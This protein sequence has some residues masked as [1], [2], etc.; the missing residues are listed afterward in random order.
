MNFRLLVAGLAVASVAGAC[1]GGDGDDRTT[2]DG[3]TEATNREAFIR[4]ADIICSTGTAAKADAMSSL[5]A[6]GS[7]GPEPAEVQKALG[8]VLD[9]TATELDKIRALD[10]PESDD[11]AVE[12]L[13]DETEATLDSVRERIATPEGAME[14][15]GSTEDP[16][17]ATNQ[18]L[19]DYGF[20]DCAGQPDREVT[21][22]FGG[23]ELTSD[24]RGGAT[25]VDVRA[26]EYAFAGVPATLPPKAAVFEFGNDGAEFHEMGLIRLKDGVDPAAALAKL[27]AD[28]DDRSGLERFV[29]AAMARPGERAAL[30]AKLTPGAYA[31][32]CLLETPDGSTHIAE[33]M[34]G[35][36]TVSVGI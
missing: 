8:Q 27:A 9:L 23:D 20:A 19:A 7:E 30:T 29:G 4:A 13:L 10:R 15:L 28:P 21:Q 16:F 31:F 17:A 11:A 33:G 3:A 14:V 18:K 22:T 36:F 24:E 25:D 1:S 35:F 5:A 2:Q 26:S 12:E 34:S 32:V 6:A